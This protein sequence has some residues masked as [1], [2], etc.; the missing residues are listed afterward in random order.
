MSDH[1]VDGRMIGDG[2]GCLVFDNCWAG[3]EPVH[4]AGIGEGPVVEFRL[5]WRAVDLGK[6]Q[7]AAGIHLGP[8]NLVRS[9]LSIKIEGS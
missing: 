6:C 3:I 4:L 7:P 8:L 9:I 5:P 2:V 1:Y